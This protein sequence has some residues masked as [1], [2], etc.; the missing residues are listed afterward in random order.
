MNLYLHIVHDM[1]GRFRHSSKEV[2][3]W[4]RWCYIKLF[5]NSLLK[6][7]EKQTQ[8]YEIIMA[9]RLCELPKQR[10]KEKKA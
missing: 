3:A 10:K 4:C 1:A 5:T 2:N 8:F 6:N 7:V 9:L